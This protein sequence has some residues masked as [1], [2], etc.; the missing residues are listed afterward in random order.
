[1]GPP[2]ASRCRPPPLPVGRPAIA[3]SGRRPGVAQDWSI[4]ARTA[5]ASAYA[6]PDGPQD[7][8]PADQAPARSGADRR[9]GRVAGLDRACGPGPR[10][11]EPT[12]PH[13]PGNGEPVRR[14]EKHRPGE[15]VHVDVKKYSADPT[16]RRVAG[17]RSGGRSSAQRSVASDPQA[18][19][20]QGRLRVHPLDAR[21]PFTGGLLRGPRRR[22]RGDHGRV[23]E[24]ALAHFA[25]HGSPGREVLT[26][27][28]PNYLS[29]AFA[30]LPRRPRHQTPANPAIP[31]P[32]QR[33]GRAVPPHPD[34]R[35]GLRQGLPLRISPPGSL[36]TM[37]T[38]LQ[39]SQTP[40]RTRRS[41]A[42]Q[43]RS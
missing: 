10:G 42:R 35:M 7:Q 23:L 14:Y 1:M 43:P 13:R 4:V 32:D 27:N 29:G 34:Q 16:R 30:A 38:H 21:R 37:A 24:R 17:P 11:P 41:T 5:S 19:T 36:A 8:A 39:P 18:K 28:G 15:Q 9:P 2:S 3:R 25:E 40:H 33:Q 20:G 22:D 26:D 31:T 6:R 12:D